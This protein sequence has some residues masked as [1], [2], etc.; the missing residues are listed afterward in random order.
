[1]NSKTYENYIERVNNRLQHILDSMASPAGRFNEAMAY[2][3]FPGGKR[4]RPMLCYLSGHMLGLKPEALDDIAAS[5]ELIHTYSLV[6]DDLPAMDDD[7]FRRGKPSV[8]R[9]YNE[10][11]AILVGDALNTLAFEWLLHALPASC[12][13]ETTLAVSKNLMQ[14]SG[15]RGMIAGQYLDLMELNSPNLQIEELT[16][17]H[18]LK[19]GC[20]IQSAIEIPS[21]LKPLAEQEQ[22]QL[23]R[24]ATLLGLTFQM[25]DDYLDTYATPE[26]LGKNR[27]SDCAQDKRTFA[28][29]FDEATL[30]QLIDQNATAAITALKPFGALAESLVEYTDV[31]MQRHRTL[32]T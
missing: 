9:A 15:H 28:H 11:T 17:I 32:P 25:Q 13:A 2:S 20:L 29:F 12:S 22:Q 26:A 8:H 10:A 5:I 4:L 30:Y 6:H 31:L 14:S 18:Q 24:F 23:K 16:R 3:L 7:D 19:T 27:H 1:M 21:I